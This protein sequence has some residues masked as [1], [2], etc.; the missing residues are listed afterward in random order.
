MKQKTH[1]GA[2]KRI[3]MPKKG[4]G[5]STTMLKGAIRNSHLKRKD[6]AS[7]R[8]KKKRQTQVSKGFTKRIKRLINI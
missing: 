5:K 2:Q 7:T 4:K 3:K 8:H 6:G 1:K